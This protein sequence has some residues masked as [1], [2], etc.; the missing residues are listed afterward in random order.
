MNAII[1]A[2][3][4]GSRLRP[5]TYKTPKPLIKIFGKPML[6]N[7]IEYLIEAGINEIIIVVGY[8]KGEFF[9]LEKKYK[10]VKL[11]YNEKFDQY[12]N[13]YS[14]YLI[15]NYLKDS[16]ILDGDI[17]LR[18]NVFKQQLSN[19]SY[20]AKKIFYSN[21]EWQLILN[22]NIIKKIVIGGK[23]NYIMSGI[24]FWKEKDSK[25][26]KELVE[27]Y[28]LDL[29]VNKNLYW[30]N[31]VKDNIE[32][33]KLGIIHL[34][35]T[36][37]IEIDTLEELKKIDRIYDDNFKKIESILL[38]TK[39]KLEDIQNIENLGGMTNKNFLISIKNKK[40]VLRASGIGTEGMINRENEEKNSKKIAHLD[41]DS[42]L[43]YYDKN[44][45]NKI[46]EYIEN[47]KTL[48]SQMAKENLEKVIYILRKLHN[49]G[50]E[51]DN[52][53]DVFEEIKK[54]ELLANKEGANFYPTYE[55]VK[56]KVE[57]LRKKLKNLNLQLVSCHNDTV[58]ENF[59]LKG[60][61]LF[62]I[63]WEY[64]GMNDPM[65]DLAAYSLENNFSKREEK[66]FLEKYFYNVI[67][68]NEYLKVQIFKIL[69]DFLWSIW[70]LVKEKKG[71]KF[72][73][74]GIK[75]FERCKKMLEEINEN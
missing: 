30:D 15:R 60:D 50:V 59:I 21:D 63:D 23:N 5:L 48:N 57:N 34:N 33:F 17:Y 32:N 35:N 61:R 12:N 38:N 11:I 66:I 18:K 73:D 55:I 71:I 28:I 43:I 74:Y 72:G 53:F 41:I 37:I 69:Q 39:F 25:V 75:R 29:D 4:I 31:I 22:D 2:A 52:K 42:K 24:S 3:G 16:F 1:I 64:S 67:P 54:Y 68:K 27:K 9:Y 10:Q 49:S 45:G 65:W 13:I 26:L 14:F 56:S 58:P 70:T 19:S 62:L 44:T 47:G 20:L 46:S 8:L 6:E 7:S 51:F 40:Y 36:D